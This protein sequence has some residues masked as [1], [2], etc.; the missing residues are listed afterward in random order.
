MALTGQVSGHGEVFK[1]GD[2]R[3]KIVAALKNGKRCIYVPLDNI[4]ES[5]EL[6]IDGIEVKTMKDIYTVI[7]DLWNM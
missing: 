6:N 3:E 7:F 5:V 1:V 4:I 2:I